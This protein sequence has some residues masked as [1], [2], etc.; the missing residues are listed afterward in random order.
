MTDSNELPLVDILIGSLSEPIKLWDRILKYGTPHIVLTVIFFFFYFVVLQNTAIEEYYNENYYFFY[1]FSQLLTYAIAT[2]SIVSIH[3]H[4]ILGREIA[5]QFPVFS[6]TTRES[7]FFGWGVLLVAF[8]IVWIVVPIGIVLY[9]FAD[10]LLDYTTGAITILGWA[11]VLICSVPGMCFVSRYSLMLP[12][13]A[14]E[15]ATVLEDVLSLSDGHLLKLTILVSVIPW[16]TEVTLSQFS[17]SNS[18]LSD[19]LISIIWAVIA[20]I[21]ICL[22]SL[23]Y[24]WLKHNS[25][26]VQ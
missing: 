13:V 14:T 3:R 9:F 8:T 10:Y 16:C 2:I 20:V 1:F 15:E 5:G 24:K 12:A 26:Q 18:L 7:K 17:G 4:F 22:L 23:C 11:I 25:E 21:E 19:M 6:W